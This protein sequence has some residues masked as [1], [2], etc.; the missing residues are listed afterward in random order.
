[1]LWGLA[2]GLPLA[3]I[4]LAILLVP[5][6]VAYTET[7]V[8]ARPPGELYDHIRFQ[9]RLMRWSAWPSETGSTCTCE[10]PDGEVGARTVFFDRKGER[11]GQQEVVALETD[12]IVLK[13]TSKFP[14]Q[15]PVLTFRLEP[16]ATGTLV[17]L[18]F[19]NVIARPFNLLLR[20]FG[21]VRWTRS[22]HVKDLNGLQRY[23]EPPHQ[24]YS[25]QPASELLTV[26][27]ASDA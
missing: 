25:G 16:V 10:G 3:G 4:L 24:T 7:R 12:R 15:Q 20:L 23:A 6:Q 27:T 2:I 19:E 11:F 26:A 14:P 13:L 5:R 9:S 22:M 21:I 17:T 18:Q 1:M 8:I